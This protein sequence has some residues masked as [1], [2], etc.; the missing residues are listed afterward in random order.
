MAD[1]LVIDNSIVMAW[2]FEDEASAYTDAIQELLVD[3]TAVV[4][5][6]WPLEV[7]NVLLVAERKKRIS[8]VDSGHFVALLSQ[9][10]IEVEPADSDRVFHDVLSLARQHQLSSY[11]ASY[12]DLAIRKGVPI[13]SLDKAIIRAAKEI[14][15]HLIQKEGRQRFLR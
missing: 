8:K 13:A 14:K 2:C 9:L 7:A 11:D 4:P 10:P 3:N 5:A 6:I 15:V 12:L 1:R